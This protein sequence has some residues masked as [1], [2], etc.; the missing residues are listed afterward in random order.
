MA[1]VLIQVQDVSLNANLAERPP[2]RISQIAW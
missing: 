2:I 1:A